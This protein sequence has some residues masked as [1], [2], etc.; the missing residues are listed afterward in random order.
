MHKLAFLCLLSC[1]LI[2]FAVQPG[3][4]TNVRDNSEINTQINVPTQ[5]DENLNVNSD[6]LGIKGPFSLSAIYS[7]TF[8]LILEGKY[9]QLLNSSNALALELDGGKAER[10][11]GIT[12]GH[13]LTPHQRIKLTAENLSQKMDFDF[14]SGNVSK[15]VYQNA[16]GG[17]YEY[18]LTNKFIKDINLNASYSKANSQDLGSK[19]FSQ[20]GVLFRNYRRIAG[21]TDKSASAGVDISPIKSTLIGL[22]L[23]YDDVKYDMR[24]Q[25][26]P[27]QNDAGVGATISVHQLVNDRLQ[28][29][30]LASDRKPYKD[31]QAEVDW[32]LNSAPGSQLQLGLIGEKIDANFG[33]PN[34]N[35]VGLQLSYSWGGDST[36]HPMTFTDPVPSNDAGGLKDWTNTPAVHMSQVLAIKDQRTEQINSE[37][38]V[39]SNKNVGANDSSDFGHNPY[40]PEPIIHGPINIGDE[41]HLRYGDQEHQDTCPPLFINQNPTI[42]G[43]DISYSGLPK[44]GDLKVALTKWTMSGHEIGN[45]FIKI[46]GTPTQADFD[47]NPDHCIDIK[48]TAHKMSRG[49]EIDTAIATI[50]IQPAIISPT[51]T[52][53]TTSY[54]VNA[55]EPIN[56][57][58]LATVTANQGTIDPSTIKLDPDLSSH[59]I[60]LDPAYKTDCAGKSSCEIKLAGTAVKPMFDHSEAA[61]LHVENTHSGS[62]DASFDVSVGGVPQ[63]NP[64]KVDLNTKETHHIGETITPVENLASHFDNPIASG[65]IDNSK[66]VLKENGVE[67]V[68]AK[69]GIAVD[70]SGR[71]YSA[72]PIP[73]SAP[74]GSVDIQVYA[75]N[76]KAGTSKTCAIYHLAIETKKPDIQPLANAVFNYGD[77]SKTSPEVVKI[78]AGQGTFKD[79]NAIQIAAEQ[80]GKELP[81]YNLEKQIVLADNNKV[82][83]III[84]VKDGQAVRRPD[85]SSY[86]VIA[87]NTFGE[88]SA[89]QHAF[90]VTINTD[91]QAPIIQ[92]RDGAFKEGSHIPINP[93]P[94]AATVYAGEGEIFSHYEFDITIKPVGGDQ[95]PLSYYN[96][97]A[98]I[99]P[100]ESAKAYTV[101]FGDGSS[102]PIKNSGSQEYEVVATSVDKATKSITKT[103]T[104][105]FTLTVT[106][107][108]QVKIS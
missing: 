24:Y 60:S 74:S 68:T 50:K 11:V 19:D 2:L 10:R 9:S 80:T 65:D 14:D 31:Y 51:I 57:F 47:E 30:L 26:A 86:T 12:W 22:Q 100:L 36:S 56:H 71:L 21:A 32:L 37:S 42:Y 54:V 43:M 107:K 78:V 1:P 73:E 16:I 27:N 25:K 17:S 108:G 102:D 58:D 39:S 93:G 44:S 90:T 101:I 103:S 82:A 45:N 20:S 46:D 72:Q 84:K 4:P 3:T 40:Y 63:I 7:K 18:L 29:S 70:S 96:I 64:A 34:D 87:T 28:F 77:T 6:M 106:P 48:I 67:D 79:V 88:T 105:Y 41:V 75:T 85:K 52:M 33:L 55:G 76:T 97:S 35:R 92:T 49:K 89:L 69:Y 8:G 61:K 66:F 59:G 5:E 23:N 98:S 53:H 95:H 94:V 13:V 104:G 15:W 91:A 62:S 99:Q 38:K 83:Y 81:Y